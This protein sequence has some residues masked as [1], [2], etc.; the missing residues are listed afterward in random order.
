MGGAV[1]GVKA[2]RE[3][4]RAY[5]SAG[6]DLIKVMATGGG[7][8][9][10]TDPRACQFDDPEM[11]ALVEEA[12]RLNRPVACHAHADAGVAQAIA[13]GVGTIEHGSY[14]SEASLRAMASRG[15]AL[16]PT[17]SPAVAALAQDLPA[18]RRAAILDR[19]D[20]RRAA[21]RAA[22][23]IGVPVV[24][25]TDAGVAYTIHGTVAAEVS[26]LVACGLPSDIALASCW[27]VAAQ[28]L[29]AGDIGVLAP[30]AHGDLIVLDDDPRRDIH[31]LARPR[32]V[33]R[34]GRW[35]T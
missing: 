29:G 32:A 27:R 10:Q 3:A 13:A 1:R 5:V 33:M 18:G 16:V 19:F 15:I 14:V 24:A 21:V 28:A 17:V 30:G 31:T 4:V 9:P 25:G 23:R 34:A 7:S 11:T 35:V 22:V 8:S 20:A 12:A 6:V 2:V 26:A